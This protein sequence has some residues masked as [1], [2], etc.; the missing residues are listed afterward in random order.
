MISFS[1]LFV[2]IPGLCITARPGPEVKYASHPASADAE[3]PLRISGEPGLRPSKGSGNRGIGEE[4]IGFVAGS[5]AAFIVSG[6]DGI[7]KSNLPPSSVLAVS[8]RLPPAKKFLLH[9]ADCTGFYRKW[10]S[11]IIQRK[12][13]VVACYYAIVTDQLLIKT[14][15]RRFT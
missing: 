10:N 9:S 7:I 6:Q 1:W 8:S 5:T 13:V 14:P 12:V 2:S 4:L 11:V 15:N 3:N